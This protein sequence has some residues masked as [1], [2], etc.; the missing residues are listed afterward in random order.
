MLQRVSMGR[1]IALKSADAA[2]CLLGSEHMTGYE[3]E[4]SFDILYAVHE[5][6][7]LLGDLYR[8]AGA[9]S[10]PVLV[11]AHGGAFQFGDRKFYQYWG[12]YLSRPRE[13]ARWDGLFAWDECCGGKHG[14]KIDAD[15]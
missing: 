8:P 2:D 11:A 12:P 5:G 3:T 7:E 4:T 6:V 15:G 13:N 14:G 1:T 9:Q 10:A